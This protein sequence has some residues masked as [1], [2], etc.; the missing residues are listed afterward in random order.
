MTSFSIQTTAEDQRIAW[1]TA[2]AITIHIIESA[3]PSPLPGVKPGLAN[4]VTITVLLLY[5]WKTAAWVS[6]LRVLAGSLILGTFLSPT[7]LLSLSG[8]LCAIL[9]L[10][11]ASAVPGRGFGPMGFSLLAALAHMAGQV[12]VAY[13]AFVPHPGIWHLFPILLVFAAVLGT[14]NGLITLFV[15]KRLT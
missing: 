10:W 1:F 15:L 6:M 8:A 11:V 13:I 2:L 4:V 12:G 5:G 7:F 14:I 9:A 3:L